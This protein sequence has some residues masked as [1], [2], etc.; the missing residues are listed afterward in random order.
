MSDQDDNGL[1]AFIARDD[2]LSW[3]TAEAVDM[4]L[5]GFNKPLLPGKDMAWLAMAVRRSLAMTMRHIEDGPDRTSNADIRDELERLR[6]ISGAAWRALFELSRASDS[7]LFRY[8][9]RSWNGEGGIDI[10]DGIELYDPVDYQRFKAAVREMEWMSGFL[11]DASRTIEK[12]QGP[13]KE[14]HKKQIR[15]E[16]GQFLA[17]IFEAAFGQPAK[18]NNWTLDTAHIS[19]TPF[20]DFYQR[21]VALAFDEKATPDLAGVLKKACRLHKQTPVEFAEGRIPGV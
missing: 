6:A 9:F 17:P 5:I 14:S 21:M 7:H 10:G 19:K 13:W 2:W 18:A 16:R 12:Q 15:I 1:S 4:A 11:R 20:M 3:M 8:A